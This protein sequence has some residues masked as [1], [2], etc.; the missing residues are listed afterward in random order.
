[1]AYGYWKHGLAEREACFHLTFRR[2]PFGGGYAIAAGL[3]DALDYLGSLHFEEEDVAY[4]ATLTGAQGLRLFD[5]GFLAYL[6][7][8]RFTGEVD[9][10]PEGT[11]V[12]AHEPLL[13]VTA[14]LL[15]AQLVETP[16]LN[17]VNFQTLVATK[18]RRICGAAGDRPVLEF[19]L[20]RA[21]GIDGGLAASRAA[22]LGGC[23]GTS[24]VLAGRL[25]GIPVR[26]THAHSWIMTFGDENEAFERYADA[27]PDNCVF[28]V[29]TYDTIRG[30][31]RAIEV[32]R[33]MRAEG[34]EMLGVRLDSGD[35]AALSIEARRLL[36]E[37]G[38]PN[39]RVV[40]SNDLDEHAIE[41][42]DAR[43]ARIG[44][45][46]IDTKLATCFDQPALGG[47][48]KL[49]AIREGGDEW[50]PR[51]KLSDTPIKVSNP[52]PQQVRRYSR[53]GQPALD[54]IHA[55]DAPP[56]AGAGLHPATSDPVPE[57]VPE[58]PFESLLVPA[59]RG[60]EQVYERPSL[61]ASRERAL[62]QWASLSPG[63]RKLRDPD[64]YPVALETGLAGLRQTLI[65][66]AREDEDET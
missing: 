21:Q 3:G 62:A 64:P 53:E 35:L 38:F 30:V 19:G 12:F 26:G 49:A 44:T 34:H 42:L 40:A 5:D 52:L 32:G 48:Y 37:A 33:R 58:L 56:V 54:V 60:G 17:L 39:A 16:L 10:I 61:S 22:Y 51:V 13:R 6:R 43:G 14:P 50:Q 7:D 41:A 36:D 2:P 18:S 8:L 11:A 15:L 28:L 59:M 24:H 57:A 1:M 25:Y 45:F 47:V 29:D 9:A 55:T 65:D 66:E 31:E 23:A 63:V 46:G 27:M 4:L 20:R